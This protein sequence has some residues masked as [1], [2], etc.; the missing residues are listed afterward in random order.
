M[1]LWLSNGALIRVI[2]LGY[3]HPQHKKCMNRCCARIKVLVHIT[4]FYGILQKAEKHFC[5]CFAGVHLMQVVLQ[6]QTSVWSAA[7]L[8]LNF[9]FIS[10]MW[11]TK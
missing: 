1:V 3:P 10:T 4:Y 7:L 2:I 5:K 9:K 11:S 8:I 6:L